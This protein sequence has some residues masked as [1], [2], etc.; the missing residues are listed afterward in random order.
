VYDGCA[1][2]NG[3]LVEVD[4]EY[5]KIIGRAKEVINVGGHQSKINGKLVYIGFELECLV[6]ESEAETLDDTLNDMQNGRLISIIVSLLW[7]DH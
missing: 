1:F 3:D 5:I 2:D 6:D 4:G 7:T